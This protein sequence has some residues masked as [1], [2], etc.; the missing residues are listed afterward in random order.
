MNLGLSKRQKIV[1]AAIL[2]TIGLVSTQITT[3]FS[4]RSRFIIGLSLIAYLVSF[5]ALRE[6]L[7]KLKAIVLLL[8]PM[9]FVL[10]VSSFYFLLPNR[11][12]TRIPVALVF[13]MAFYCLLLAQNVFNVAAIRT[14]PLYR[15]AST[16]AFLF[17]LI[18]SFFLYNVIFSLKMPF[19][20]N[21]LATTLISFPLILQILWSIEMERLTGQIILYSVILS[22]VMGESALALSF[23]PVAP[24]IWS[25]SLA[26]ILYTILGVITQLLKERLNRQVAWEYI[27]IA[28]GILIFSVLSTSWTG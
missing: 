12:L 18:T 19:Y 14:I 4:V 17:T 3:V 13:G 28:L 7:T 8:L 10:A 9:M 5:W 26:T 6:G 27:G 22:I 25:L 20:W 1:A 11:W 23:W 2:I 24:T 16:V 15:A 21:A